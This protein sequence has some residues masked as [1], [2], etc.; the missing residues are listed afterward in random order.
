MNARDRSLME[1]M[2]AFAADAVELGDLDAAGLRA[3]KRSQYAV[4]RAVEVLGEA[5]SKVDAE[6]RARLSELPWRAAIGM[7]NILIH[8]YHQ[9]DLALVVKTVRE[10]LPPLVAR[11]EA[12]LGDDPE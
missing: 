2:R 10:D 11:L 8:G 9:L 3:D 4:I 1:D 12:I 6:T 5:A 7:R